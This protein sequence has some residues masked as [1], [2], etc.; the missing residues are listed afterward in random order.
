MASIAQIRKG[1]E[2]CIVGGECQFLTYGEFNDRFQISG[3]TRSW[4]NRRML[5][6]VAAEFR[7]ATP[8][9]LDLTF[10][11]RNGRTKYPSVIDGKPSKP[12]TPEQKRRAHEVAQKIIDLYGPSTRNPYPL[13]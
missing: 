10:L 5:D 8:P 2:Q 12:P 6:A 13:T 1:L 3:H 4:A 7:K 11:L 9:K